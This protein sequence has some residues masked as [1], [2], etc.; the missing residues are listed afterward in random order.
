LGGLTVTLR[1]PF[2][3]DRQ[4]V[5]GGDMGTS[6][7]FVIWKD[8][9]TSSEVI[10][11]E[12]GTT[13]VGEVVHESERWVFNLPRGTHVLN[14]TTALYYLRARYASS[15]FD[16]ARRQQEALIGMRDKLK[17]LGILLNPLKIN[18]L[19]RVAERHITTDISLSQLAD[20]AGL[21]ARIDVSALTHTVL[22]ASEGGYLTARRNEQG[23]YV[24]EPRDGSFAAIRKAARD[25]F[26]PNSTP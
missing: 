19:L 10:A 24:L 6:S 17:S 4:W 8:T 3:E 7:M 23:L 13:S 12:D 11:H 22:D 18:E 9:A 16:R 15:D 2:I 26:A 21:A 25:V 5:R 20:L 14:G 1:Q